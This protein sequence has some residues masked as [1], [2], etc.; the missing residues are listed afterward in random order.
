MNFSMT[1]SIRMLGDIVYLPIRSDPVKGNVLY[2]PA[3][4]KING[5]GLL[6]GRAN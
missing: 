3:P 5:E 1:G 2:S 4:P 6:Q